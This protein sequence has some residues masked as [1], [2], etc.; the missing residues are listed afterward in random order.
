[1]T[2]KVGAQAPTS[3]IIA[4]RNGDEKYVL[5]VLA[6]VA[7]L[8]ARSAAA[9]ETS[10]VV[11]VSRGD[12]A[13]AEMAA[14]GKAL[15]AQHCSHCHGFNMVNPGAVAYDLRQFPREDKAQVCALRD[16]RQ[17]R[18]HAAMARHAECG[19]NRRHLG[20]REDGR[21]AVKVSFLPALAIVFL[22]AACGG[23]AVRAEDRNDTPLRVCL[24]E[25]LRPFLFATKRAAR[26]STS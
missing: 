7:A 10:P 6:A 24:N 2:V 14:K 22:C 23:S 5:F 3:P 16:A 12:R 9:E 1:M 11:T 25:D 13:E 8:P 20:L 21:N 18:T 19:R 4:I 26:V 17:K 15:Y